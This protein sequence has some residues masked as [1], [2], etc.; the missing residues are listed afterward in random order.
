MSDNAISNLLPIIACGSMLLWGSMNVLM[1]DWQS[2]MSFNE[3]YLW[4]AVTHL[5]ACLC[6]PIHFCTAQRSSGEDRP[7]APL[8][9]FVMA[10]VFEFSAVM[11]VNLAYQGLPGS[12][13]Q[14]MKVLKLIFTSLLSVTFLQKTLRSY[15]YLGVCMAS[16]GV[17]IVGA[18]STGGL[19]TGWASNSLAR[20]SFML[21]VLSSF[22]GALSFVWEEKIMKQYEVEPLLLSGM[23]G[24][25]GVVMSL[26][27]LCVAQ[28]LHAADTPAA[29][30]VMWHKPEI[31]CAFLLFSIAVG[32]FNYSSISVTRYTSAL[33][34]S[35][36]DVGRTTLI[37]FIEIILKWDRFSWPELMG[38][39][40]LISGIM[41]Y[42]KQLKV[43]CLSY[44]EEETLLPVKQKQG[45]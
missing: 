37:W 31:L 23:E 14:M 40:I 17:I 41:I 25:I 21:V 4:T 20:G 2:K 5:I 6:L 45:K 7:Q 26:I 32:F 13:L 33:V 15:Q 44:E 38:F 16:I 27:V 39:V 35:L 1:K 9:T 30:V 22:V 18:C 24:F 29:L 10:T 12:V 3:P 36:L 19:G 43:P 28:V 42:G 11:F 34:R 8:Y